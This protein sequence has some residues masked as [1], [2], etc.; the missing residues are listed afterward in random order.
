[1]IEEFTTRDMSDLLEADLNSIKDN[2]NPIQ[3]LYCKIQQQ[4]VNFR[5]D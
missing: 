5:V 2:E 1:M 4:R 3:K